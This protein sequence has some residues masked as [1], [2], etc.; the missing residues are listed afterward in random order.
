MIEAVGAVDSGTQLAGAG[1]RRLVIGDRVLLGTARH[2]ACVRDIDGEVA[3]FDSPMTERGPVT[4]RAPG[5]VEL[6]P[7]GGT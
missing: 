3:W 4:L 7:F 5:L 2:P 1:V 6:A